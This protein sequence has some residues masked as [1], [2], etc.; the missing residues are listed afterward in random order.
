MISYLIGIEDD[1]RTVLH[2]I[3]VKSSHYLLHNKLDNHDILLD[4]THDLRELIIDYS[5]YQFNY[6]P[7]KSQ[8]NKK[9]L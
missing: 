5:R 9:S 8:P 1:R 7:R 6:E 4:V 2:D 3:V